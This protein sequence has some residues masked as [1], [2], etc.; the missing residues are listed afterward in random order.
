MAAW[1]WTALLQGFIQFSFVDSLVQMGPSWKET[2]PLCPLFS[3]SPLPSSGAQVG[4]EAFIT[5]P[6]S[7]PFHQLLGWLWVLT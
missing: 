2:P 3:V 1:D 5:C 6:S 7:T 4:Q